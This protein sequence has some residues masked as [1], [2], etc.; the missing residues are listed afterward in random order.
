MFFDV[1]FWKGFSEPEGFMG[2]LKLSLS[3]FVTRV[4]LPPLNLN[5]DGLSDGAILFAG[6]EGFLGMFMVAVFGFTLTCSIQRWDSRFD[7]SSRHL[8]I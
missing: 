3:A 5:P 6:A 8:P 4:P 7:R 2:S 1:I